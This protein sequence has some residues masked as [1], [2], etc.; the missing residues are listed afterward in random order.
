VSVYHLAQWANTVPYEII[1]R[2]GPRV[3]RV[4]VDPMDGEEI[5]AMVDEESEK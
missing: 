4:G 5:T 3:K 1:S 2:I